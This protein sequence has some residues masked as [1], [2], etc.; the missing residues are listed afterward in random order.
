MQFILANGLLPGRV[1]QR[2][3]EQIFDKDWVIVLKTVEVPQLQFIVGLGMHQIETVQKTVE[4][5]QLPSRIGSCNSWTR[6]RR[7]LLYNNRC[8][9]YDSVEVPPPQIP[10]NSF[11]MKSPA[12]A[13]A[14]EPLYRFYQRYSGR[15]S[16]SKLHRC[17]FR[18]QQ[19]GVVQFLDQVID[20]PVVVLVIF[21]RKVFSQ[22]GF[23]SVLMSRS[24]AFWVTVL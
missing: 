6:L 17:A 16:R 2:F 5:P 14:N 23:S 8:L 9:G 7:P 3:D 18:F 13:N 21:L 4:V 15:S 11:F 1:L 12:A 20:V 19:I 24:S 22:D 10:K